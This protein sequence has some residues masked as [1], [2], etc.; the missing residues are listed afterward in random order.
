MEDTIMT[1]PVIAL[2]GLTV[3]PHMT[4]SFDISRPKSISAVERRWWEIRRSVW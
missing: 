1:M 2:R 3:L 4:V